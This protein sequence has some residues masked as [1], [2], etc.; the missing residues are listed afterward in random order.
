MTSTALPTQQPCASVRMS[1]RDG[2]GKESD[3]AVDYPIGA[4]F[5]ELAPELRRVLGLSAHT[6]MF[7]GD[8]VLN[9]HDRLGIGPLRNGQRIT[10]GTS[11]VVEENS[12]LLSIVVTC[13]PDAGTSHVLPRGIST[14][15]RG[16]DCD[17]RLCDPDTSRIHAAITVT[18]AGITVRDLDSTNGTYI[19]GQQIT[20]GPEPLPHGAQV[21]IGNTLLQIRGPENPPLATTTTDDGTTLVMRP[22]RPTP[23][24][25]PVITS[26]AQPRLEPIRPQQWLASLLPAVLGAILA[27]ALHNLMFLL[28]AL[29]SPLV[30]LGTGLGERLSARRHHHRNLRRTRTER[31]QNEQVLQDALRKET[32]WRRQ[33]HAD[34]VSVLRT[35]S[36]PDS[37]LWERRIGDNDFLELRFGCSDQP[38]QTQQHSGTQSRSAGIT[39]NVPVVAHIAGNPLGIHGPRRSALG[40]ARWLVGQ[41]CATHSPAELKLIA[42]VDGIGATEWQW[43]RWLPH[44]ETVAT[45]TTDQ[46]NVVTELLQRRLLPSATASSSP[47]WVVLLIDSGTTTAEI[48]DLDVLLTESSNTRVSAICVQRTREQL[49]DGIRIVARVS[50]ETGTYLE[51]EH[52]EGTVSTLADQVGSSWCDQLA[53]SLAPLRDG[54]TASGIPNSYELWSALTLPARSDLQ[55]QIATEQIADRWR[56]SNRCSTVIGHGIHGP[57]EIDLDRDGPHVLVAGTTGAGKSEL[58]QSFIA[59][60]ATQCAPSEVTF[61]LVDYKGGAAFADCAD[62][63][64]VVGLVTDLDPQLTVRALTSLDAELRRREQLLRAA[65]A[66]DLNQYRIQGYPYGP[67]PRLVLIIDE[68][69]TLADELPTFIDG[70]V[71]LAQRG[72]SLGIHLVLATQRP[73]GVVSA[74]I[75]ANV[76]LRIALRVTDAGDSLDV[77]DDPSAARLPKNTPGR[78]LARIG[79]EL[80]EF[81]VA[82]VNMVGQQVRSELQVELLDNWGRRPPYTQSNHETPSD[83]QLLTQ[84]LRQT[85]ATLQLPAAPRPWL[86]PLP[87]AL[88]AAQI[89]NGRASTDPNEIAIGLADY[90]ENQS[91]STLTINLSEPQ[92]ILFSAGAKSGK[93]TA[94]L[95]IATGAASAL[96]PEALHL[97]LLDLGGSM[98]GLASLPHTAAYTGRDDPATVSRVLRRLITQISRNGGPHTSSPPAH[99]KLL[100]IDDWETLCTLSDEHDAGASVEAAV[101][102]MRDGAKAGITVVV[103]GGR[104]TLTS[105]ICGLA[106]ERYVLSFPDRADYTLAGIPCSNLPPGRAIRAG[107]GVHVQFAAWHPDDTSRAAA[108]WLPTTEAK[109][110]PQKIVALPHHVSHGELPPLH[111]TGTESRNTQLTEQPEN[112]SKIQDIGRWVR[113]GLGGD[114]GALISFDLATEPEFLIAG[115]PRSGRSSALRL[116]LTEALTS[117]RPQEILVAAGYRSAL[118]THARTMGV[119]TLSPEDTTFP[120]HPDISVVLVDDAEAFL[121]TAAGDLLLQIHRQRDA[122][123]VVAARCDELA[124]SFRGLA[125]QIRKTRVGMLLNPSVADGDLLGL[126]LPRSRTP[127]PAGRGVLVSHQPH[128]IPLMRDEP[129]LELQLAQI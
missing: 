117:T 77:I 121:D 94:A 55:N 12:A 59:G 123:M 73:A 45:T 68:F 126:R 9:P 27:Y 104:A 109:R 61:V 82:R 54:A 38:A 26:A 34:P 103:T 24:I 107:D 31:Q 40:S 70:L 11:R 95:S 114:G 65:Q 78:A 115:G 66:Q 49:P 83:L 81:Q 85:A 72:R 127:A 93:S 119:A 110:L 64:H 76:T 44:T 1:V 112:I 60:L 4:T 91:Q 105:R 56:H 122:S 124:V 125:A 37:R 96:S 84:L 52:S 39:H 17:L 5:S 62:L 41:L 69:A 3:V 22:P 79:T 32:H 102:L 118:L 63:P 28:F 57:F 6:A 23:W 106:Q 16:A 43:L 46:H 42:L 88:T 92:T 47:P 21:R 113:L 20:D 2:H 19:D 100:V 18:S 8:Q 90:P 80:H 13:G 74:Q 10:I 120:D 129:Y 89:I 86:D 14:I 71:S 53:R 99:K 111:P 30:A 98:H 36:G 87:A 48:T 51:I 25:A 7:V 58:L 116:I 101:T 67:L 33:C 29:M 35:T 15:G 128:L 50:G 97:Y 108:R 75:K